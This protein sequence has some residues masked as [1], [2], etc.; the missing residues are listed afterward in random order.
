MTQLSDLFLKKLGISRRRFNAAAGDGK[1][2]SSHHEVV[3]ALED[4]GEEAEGDCSVANTCCGA[5][6]LRDLDRIGAAGVFTEVANAVAMH[7]GHYGALV[8]YSADKGTAAA[9]RKYGFKQ[10][11][12]FVNPQTG[13]TVRILTLIL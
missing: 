7:Q 1:D 5:I 8:Y 6:E 9:L 13:N 11:G 2:F 3:G 4:A 10:A 12:K